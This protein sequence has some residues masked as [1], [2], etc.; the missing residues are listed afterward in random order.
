M[1]RFGFLLRFLLALLIIGGLVAGGVALYR[2]GYAQGYQTAAMVLANNKAA[3]PGVPPVMP[4]YGY[5][6]PFVYHW[7]FGFPFFFPLIGIGFF[8]LFFFLI[9]GLFRFGMYRRWAHAGGGR[10][11]W[12]EGEPG[13]GDKGEETPKNP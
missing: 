3:A 5:G 7:G 8:L 2:T 12:Q 1:F 9:G 10:W 11:V 6:Y 13:K 4:Y